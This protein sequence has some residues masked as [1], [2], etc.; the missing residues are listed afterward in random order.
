M[1]IIEET[2]QPKPWETGAVIVFIFLVLFL[3]VTIFFG[4][5]LAWF[6][7]ELALSSLSIKILYQSGWIWFLIQA[8]IL[9]LVSGIAFY[10]S[11]SGFRP[12]YKSWFLATILSF[13][14]I[15]LSILDPNLDQAGAFLQILIALISAAIMLFV[16]RKELEWSIRQ[17][18]AVLLVVS[19]C[20]WPFVLWGALGSVGEVI[21]YLVAG[22]AIGLLTAG[23][24]PTH[25]GNQLFDG[26]GIG[27]LLAI[28]GAAFGY[29][30]SQLLL[31]VA[32]PS[33]GFAIAR[34]G[35]SVPVVTLGVGLL[36]AAPLIFID[37]TELSPLIL[38]DL[39]PWA[40]K[41]TL[42]MSV[43][44]LLVGLAMWILSLLK[45][46]ALS[47]KLTALIAGTGWI[48]VIAIYILFGQKGFH[49]DRILVILS[50]QADVSAAEKIEDRDERLTFV[51]ETL[52][53]HANATQV[54]LRQ[55][56]DRLGVQY[57][58]YYLVNAIEV[59][60]GV[61]L[62]LYLST[63]PEVDRI[64]SSQHLRP[65]PELPFEGSGMEYTPPVE[66]GWNIQM[67]GA[68]KVW[69]EFGVNGDGIVVGQSD[70]GVDLKHTAL[71]DSY[72]GREGGNDYNWYDPW[73]N[74]DIPSDRTG[75]GTHTLGT[76][77]GNDGIGVAP[78]AQWIA[79]SNLDR[80]L[81]S[82]A[83]Y[84]DCMQFMLAPFPQKGDPF[85]DGDP[86][87]AAH[88]LN[89]S[90]GCP[91][92][93][94]C[95]PDTLKPAVEALRSA[96]IFVVVSAGND[97]PACETLQTPMALYDATFSVG[98]VDQFG[99]IAEF[100]S[101]GP[102]TI[103][104]SG[105]TKPDIMAPGVGVFSSLPGGSYGE[106]SGTSMAGPHVAGAVALLWS[107]QPSL[108][109]DI[110]R[111]EQILIETAQPYTGYVG[112]ACGSGDHPSNVYGYGLLDVYA[113]VKKALN[114]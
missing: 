105:R 48:L 12:I 86:T 85:L 34:L 47:P 96:G 59:R 103:D 84:L 107:A 63:Q 3:S 4:N 27:T 24:M 52:T 51:Y 87:R 30:G 17:V 64:V 33:F 31:L 91:S 66:A 77:L 26:L 6:L 109:G 38:A 20:T 10:V 82:P 94:G 111:T 42:L 99:N 43:F 39:F 89:N 78:N 61:L 113:A 72:R 70:T 40:L 76:V 80:N 108:I 62:R 45:L 28:L 57:E 41:A 81:A 100:S 90:W 9:V 50:D 98:A 79:C 46:T 19:L 21:S 36:A 49:G 102:V 75:H 18:P 58:S 16:R 104:G 53:E 93:E 29:D 73:G 88:V 97:G 74:T 14:T 23:L 68:D 95:D 71:A 67:I 114:E 25:S 60:G 35:R 32:L 22:L 44:G 15:G 106:N 7:E 110:N 65:L 92:I 55:R 69:Q 8:F 11:R 56:L 1:S 5:L 112:T 2:K 37:P 101:R 54:D 13:P 83:L